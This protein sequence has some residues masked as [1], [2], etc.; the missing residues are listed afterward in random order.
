MKETACKIE[1]HHHIDPEGPWG[2]EVKLK[3]DQGKIHTDDCGF[4]LCNE[5]CNHPDP[6]VHCTA[7]ERGVKCRVGRR[8]W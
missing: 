7:G 8:A 2:H 6:G 5:S 1:D 4:W 3:E